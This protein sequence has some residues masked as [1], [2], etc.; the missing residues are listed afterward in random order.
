MSENYNLL[1]Q[2]C[3]KIVFFFSAFNS[4]KIQR[5]AFLFALPVRSPVR[6]DIYFGV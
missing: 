3:F 1:I 6:F 5:E 2:T 4:L